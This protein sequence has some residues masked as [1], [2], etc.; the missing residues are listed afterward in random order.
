MLGVFADMARK[1]ILSREKKMQDQAVRPPEFSISVPIA[2]MKLEDGT[3]IEINKDVITV[4]RGKGKV[5]I[6]DHYGQMV[7]STRGDAGV[8]PGEQK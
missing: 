8:M 1:E 2:V 3:R 6:D 7:V 4:A 5:Q